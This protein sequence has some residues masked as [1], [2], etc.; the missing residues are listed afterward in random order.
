M[1]EALAALVSRRPLMLGDVI[2]ERYKLLK[3]LDGGAM[4]EVFVA[5]NLAMGKRVAVKVLRPELL[6]DAS[7]RKRIQQEAEAIAAIDH[8]NVVRLLDLLVG[9]PTFLVLE[10]VP[11]PTLAAVLS[12]EKRLA[13]TRA[14]NVALRL[15]WALDAV[16]RAGIVHR[17]IKPSNV[18][19]APDP[20]LGEE[21]KLIDFGLAKLI[22]RRAQDQLTEHGQ[23]VGTPYYIA[24]EQIGTQ[25]V[26]ARADLYALG[27]VL[28]HM[29]TGHAPFESDDNVQ[30]LYAHRHTAP[31][32]LRELV[33][34]ASPE[35][36]ALLSRVLAKEPSARFASARDLAGALLKLDRRKPTGAELP[37]R[38]ASGWIWALAG[39]V[40]AATGPAAFVLGQSRGRMS[41]RA[42]LLVTTQPAGATIDIDGKPLADP[43]PLAAAIAPGRHTV[44]ARLAGHADVDQVAVIEAGKRV[45]LDFALPQSSRTIQIQTTPPGAQVFV[46]GHLMLG[47]TPLQTSVTRDDFHSLQIEKPGYATALK[48]IVPEDDAPLVSVGLEPEKTP[49]ATLWIDANRAASVFIDGS[50]TALVT[51]TLGV[52][53]AP[54]KHVIELRDGSGTVGPQAHIDVARGETLHL[55]LDFPV[56]RAK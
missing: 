33:P 22:E 53:V 11:G 12:S 47:Q 16:H 5:E 50:D 27:C 56:E 36:E 10:Y 34:D 38:R 24:P 2:A 32:R 4:G 20:E 41:A 48:S 8:R 9:D 52:R 29:L 39:L 44:R 37:Q 25:H 19:L 18:I 49:R 51:P 54:G 17:D 30:V 55:T 26:D 1:P 43:T 42:T 23:I 28:F 45:A 46:D 6:A 21:P 15:A 40:A 14:I 31:P 3:S 13:T 35:L 7:F